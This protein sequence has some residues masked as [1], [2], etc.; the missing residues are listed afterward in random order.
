MQEQLKE[1]A[2]NLAQVITLFILLVLPTY[3]GNY[4]IRAYD[5]TEVMQLVN[6]FAGFAGFLIIYY[7]TMIFYHTKL[8]SR[9]HDL[10]YLKYLV[11]IIILFWFIYDVYMAYIYQKAFMQLQEIIVRRDIVWRDVAF[12]DLPY[13]VIYPNFRVAYLFLLSLLRGLLVALIAYDLMR[14]KGT[15]ALSRKYKK[16]TKRSEKSIEEIKAELHPSVL[17]GYQNNNNPK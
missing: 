6:V 7:F 15:S 16:R 17:K 9:L 12:A 14:E 4:L 13:D 3:L 5:L 8:I 1:Y 10:V 2:L 11:V